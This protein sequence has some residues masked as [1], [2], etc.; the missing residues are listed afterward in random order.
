[1]AL[2]LKSVAFDVDSLTEDWD[3]I[4][5]NLVKGSVHW[6]FM[7][8]FMVRK[9]MFTFTFWAVSAIWPV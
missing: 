6:A 8:T 9:F 4:Q 1:M 5:F 7:F 3:S 2:N